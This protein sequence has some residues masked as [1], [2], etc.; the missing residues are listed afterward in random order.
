METTTNWLS[1]ELEFLGNIRHYMINV[2]KDDSNG[3]Y[4][5]LDV[6]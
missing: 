5:K 2:W 6:I 4:N 3:N 1:P